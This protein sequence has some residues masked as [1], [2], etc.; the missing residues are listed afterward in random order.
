MH[1]TH[2]GNETGFK[3]QVSLESSHHNVN[4]AIYVI[5]MLVFISKNVG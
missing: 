3:D 2:F 1:T 4:K 5:F